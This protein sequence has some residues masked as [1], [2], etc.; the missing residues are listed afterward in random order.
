MAIFGLNSEKADQSL[1]DL[2]LNL[3]PITDEEWNEI[4]EAVETRTAWECRTQWSNHWHPHIKQFVNLSR[5]ERES[6]QEFL[7]GN[8][9]KSWVDIAAEFPVSFAF[10][11]FVY[12]RIFLI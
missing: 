8:S 3:Q 10:N 2:N 12:I 7:K 9:E 6:I 1:D 11:L 4:A 5:G